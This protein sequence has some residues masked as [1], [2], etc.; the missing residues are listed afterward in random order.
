M[1]LVSPYQCITASGIVH[2]VTYFTWS[3]TRHFVFIC[4]SARDFAR[5]SSCNHG[6]L[7][8][9]LVLLWKGL[10][11]AS[12]Y[13]FTSIAQCASKAR[14]RLTPHL[15]DLFFTWSASCRSVQHVS[16][17]IYRLSRCR[18]E[19]STPV[20]NHSPKRHGHTIL[21][22]QFV[23][24]FQQCHRFTANFGQGK[25]SSRHWRTCWSFQ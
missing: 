5:L 14:L 18:I 2:V 19:R 25:L 4:L 12:S 21:I 13:Y 11:F 20:Q 24:H 6:S 7:E 16:P 9:V 23:D 8:L 10:H 22:T 1:S 15:N 17:H 3:S